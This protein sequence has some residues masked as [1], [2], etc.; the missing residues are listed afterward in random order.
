MQR[1]NVTHDIEG[2]KTRI[3]AEWPGYKAVNATWTIDREPEIIVDSGVKDGVAWADVE[4]GKP[5]CQ[6]LLI[7]E[8]GSDTPGV[9]LRDE[10]WLNTVKKSAAPSQTPRAAIRVDGNA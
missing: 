3:Q 8:A 4:G 9:K 10:I 5:F 2:G 7:V 6:Y 1:Q